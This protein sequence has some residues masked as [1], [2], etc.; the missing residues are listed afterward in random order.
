[1]KLKLSLNQLTDEEY[2][3]YFH[4][5]K[6]HLQQQVDALHMPQRVITR[7]RYS[8]TGNSKYKNASVHVCVNVE[9]M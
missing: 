5:K 9:V 6:I 7:E 2:Q 1:M 8:A 3:H 4:F